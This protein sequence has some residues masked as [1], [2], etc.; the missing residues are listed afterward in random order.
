M[1]IQI[2]FIDIVLPMLIAFAVS[3]ITGHFLIPFLIRMKAEQTERDVGPK[4]HSICRFS[5]YREG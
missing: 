3:A 2:S 5:I 4:S 1:N